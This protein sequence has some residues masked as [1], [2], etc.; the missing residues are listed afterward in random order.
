M[1][2]KNK[3]VCLTAF[4]IAMGY[5]ESAVV[6]YL[7]EIYYPLG[8]AFPIAPMTG[9][10]ASTEVIREA[11][12][13]IMLIA[14]GWLAGERPRYKFAWFIYCFA[15]WDIFYYVFLKVLTNWPE[16]FLTWDIL[17]LIPVT[18]TGPV[19]APLIV[20]ATLI[21]LAFIMLSSDGDRS[22]WTAGRMPVILLFSGFLLIFVSLIWDFC[23]FMFAHFSVAALFHVP[24]VREAMNTY[25][26]SGFNW[27]L[28][29]A[30]E[31]VVLAGI[32]KMYAAG[33]KKSLS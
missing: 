4:S 29:V 6:V 20:S 28:F 22:L 25:I 18:W 7:R 8:F 27:L 32:Y 19:L 21:L 14:V 13:I 31:L 11:A 5:L 33:K 16:S 17:F 24:E 30:G 10:M 15:V 12:T 23:S 3:I 2:L 1:N 26:P 9:R